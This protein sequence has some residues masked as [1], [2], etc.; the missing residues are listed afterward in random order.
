MPRFGRCKFESEWVIATNVVGK[1]VE[2]HDDWIA[3]AHRIGGR[4]KPTYPNGYGDWLKVP[5]V[6]A[7]HFLGFSRMIELNDIQ[8]IFDNEKRTWP[9]SKPTET[10]TIFDGLNAR[11]EEGHA[12]A[13]RGVNGCGKTTLLRL[14]YGA[15]Y[16]NARGEVR[17]L[18]TSTAAWRHPP[19]RCSLALS[20]RL[21]S[22]VEIDH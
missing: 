8:L 12:V 18:G 13:L 7:L 6:E 22:S 20:A 14:I 1:V 9:W 17:V 10:R 2:I 11:I 16:A 3:L 15:L 19:S 5:Y 4:L 21:D